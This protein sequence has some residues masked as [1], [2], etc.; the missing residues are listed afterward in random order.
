[1]RMFAR[2]VPLALLAALAVCTPRHEA[3]DSGSATTERAPEVVGSRNEPSLF[4]LDFPLIDR[5][6]RSR[7]LREFA[8]GPLVVSMVY[9]NCRSVCPRTTADLQAL[10]KALPPDLRARTRFLLFSLDPKRDTPAALAGFAREHGLDDRWTLLAASED[11][12]RTLAAVLGV[13]FRPDAGGE[14]AHT[15]VIA[16]ADARGVLRHRQVGLGQGAA[17]LVAAVRSATEADAGT[18]HARP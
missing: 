17:P 16:V 3:R 1:M 18:R 14:I 7:H 4:E 6:G 15:A 2:L 12:M 10:A 11:D 5:E 9:T 8:G 13:R